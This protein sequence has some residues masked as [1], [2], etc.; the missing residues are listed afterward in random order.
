MTNEKEYLPK[1]AMPI[2]AHADNQGFIVVGT[3]TKW[4]EEEEM[5]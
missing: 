5:K 2:Y 4:A 3:L 1:I